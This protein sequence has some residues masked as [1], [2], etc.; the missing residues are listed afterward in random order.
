MRKEVKSNQELWDALTPVHVNSEFYDLEGFKQGRCSLNPLE[1]EELGDVQGKS[2]LHLQCHFGMDTL[3]WARRGAQVTGMDFSEPA[4]EKAK[5]LAAELKL[6]ANF[7]SCDLYDLPDQL[8][9]TYDIVFTSGGVLCWLP[10][11]PAWGKVIAKMLKPGGLFYLREFHPFQYCLD[12]REGVNEARVHY[13]YFHE[14][15]PLHFPG[16][17]DGDY[18]DPSTIV[19]KDSH[20]WPY[21]LSNIIGALLDAGLQL[22]SFREFPWT[23]YPALPILEKE[24]DDRWVLPNYPGGFPLMFSI[25]ARS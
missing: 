13:P 18:A 3:S 4:I 11:L 5:A 21:A 16:G 7:L 15:Q 25:K 19:N 24:G 6:D 20:E 1:V 17:E 12:D 10:D 8:K 2:L 23:S 22:E 14:G 9:N